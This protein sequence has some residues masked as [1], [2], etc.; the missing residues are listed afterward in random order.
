[1]K[2]KDYK[3]IRSSKIEILNLYLEDV[4]RHIACFETLQ[5]MIFPKGGWR[6]P[7]I[8]QKFSLKVTYPLKVVDFEKIVSLNFIKMLV[9]TLFYD[10]LNNK[11]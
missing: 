9:S 5:N 3:N 8:D 6:N 1:M 11:K 10:N 2:V 4:M 7:P